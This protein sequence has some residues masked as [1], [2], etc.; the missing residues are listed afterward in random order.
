[1]KKL[2][3]INEI[4]KI[5]LEKPVDVYC[6]TVIPN[7]RIIVNGIL[8]RQSPNWQQCWLPS[9]VIKTSYG[10][11]ILGDLL[12]KYKE[13]TSPYEGDVYVIDDEGKPDRIESVY[14]GTSKFLM[15]FWFKDGTEF[16]VT[17]D[18][19]CF[20]VRDDRE[21]MIPAREIQ[22]TDLFKR[23]IDGKW[24]LERYDL[25]STSIHLDNPVEVCCITT[26][27]HRV[28]VNG[29]LTSQCPKQ[30]E[31]AKDFRMIFQ[32][33]TDSRHFVYGRRSMKLSLENGEELE[34]SLY[35]NLKVNRKGEEIVIKARD[36]QKGDDFIKVV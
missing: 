32:P 27:R 12:D 7:H 14:K 2:L 16:V 8:T 25:C 11:M 36:L 9:E 3:K 23:L 30:G 10:D 21:I 28:I 15:N 24:V 19:N 5:K 35:E 26:T 4:N 29:V 6:V 33:P 34:F 31:F 17:P 20:V 22:K 13:G 18:H 1:M